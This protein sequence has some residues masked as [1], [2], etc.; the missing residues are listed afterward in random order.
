[1]LSDLSNSVTLDGPLRRSYIHLFCMLGWQT[2]RENCLVRRVW[3]L[4]AIKLLEIN[5]PL[6]C[7]SVICCVLIDGVGQWS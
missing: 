1:M 4:K 2:E 5:D 3:D 6:G 7:K